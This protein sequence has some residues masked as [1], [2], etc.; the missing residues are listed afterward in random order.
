M[1]TGVLIL[2]ALAGA[3]GGLLAWA[4]ARFPP[5]EGEADVER[6]NGLLPQTQCGQCGYPGCRPYAA[7]LVAGEAGPDLCPPGGE[8]TARL[9]ADVLGTQSQALT[10]ALADVTA[11]RPPP[12]LA[13]ID[14]AVCIG[15]VRCV[16]VCPVDAIVGAHRF[17]HTVIEADCTGCELCI[18]ACPVDCISLVESGRSGDPA[19]HWS[20]QHPPVTA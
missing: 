14:E 17:L 13:R 12:K 3:A 16:E 7:A 19:G 5:D 6:I 18:P 10:P 9:L 2:T 15:C 1:W 4:A 20:G 11:L 8:A